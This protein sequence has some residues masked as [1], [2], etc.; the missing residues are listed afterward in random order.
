MEA[1]LK[2]GHDHPIRGVGKKSKLDSWLLTGSGVGTSTGG[3][4]GLPDPHW[5]LQA[6][7]CAKASL[8]AI[9]CF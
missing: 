7:S 4:W 8:Q 9:L 2:A 1:T 6:H 3:C 5:F